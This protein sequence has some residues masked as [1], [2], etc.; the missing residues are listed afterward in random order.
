MECGLVWDVGGLTAKILKP[1]LRMWQKRD[2]GSKQ[3][4]PPGEQMVNPC[5]FLHCSSLP[6]PWQALLIND[7][8][9][10]NSSLPNSFIYSPK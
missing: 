7:D 5:R 4:T 8:E 2:L 3:Q 1:K 6:R 10:N 9:K